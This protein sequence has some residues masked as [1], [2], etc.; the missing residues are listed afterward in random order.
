MNFNKNL[1]TVIALLGLVASPVFA[2]GDENKAEQKP[3]LCKFHAKAAKKDAKDAK[4]VADKAERKAK[5]EAKDAKRKEGKEAKAVESKETKAAKVAA[6]LVVSVAKHAP[7][8][9]SCGMPMCQFF[10]Y[11]NS[12]RAMDAGTCKQHMLGLAAIAT[13]IADANDAKALEGLVTLET[14]KAKQT[15]VQ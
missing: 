3:V 1:L 12:G 2:A 6:K 14:A 8:T 15:H 11:L 5:Q 7:Q 13:A 9:C 10:G 4:Q